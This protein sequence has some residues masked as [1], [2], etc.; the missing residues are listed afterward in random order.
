MNYFLLGL[1]GWAGIIALL[2]IIHGELERMTA[3]L[4]E[5]NNNTQIDEIRKAL[6]ELTKI[7]E[8]LDRAHPE[9]TFG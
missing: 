1:F 9:P 5:I 6:K 3:L 2:W 8:I 7:R 4:G